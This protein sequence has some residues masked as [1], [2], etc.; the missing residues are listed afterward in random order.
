MFNRISAD[1]CTSKLIDYLSNKGSSSRSSSP[2]QLIVENEKSENYSQRVTKL[3]L[4]SR[5][6]LSSQT[7]KLTPK[8]KKSLFNLDLEN[9][10][11]EKTPIGTGRSPVVSPDIKK[12]STERKR[13]SIDRISRLFQRAKDLD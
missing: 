7:L 13:E 11:E 12:D 9:I 3:S 6:T 8:Y 4:P 10:K 2:R 1:I 5:K